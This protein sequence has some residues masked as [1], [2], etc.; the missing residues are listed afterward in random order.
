MELLRS[1]ESGS[2]V[3]ATIWVLAA[4]LGSGW[5]SSPAGAA[6]VHAHRGGPNAEG[7]AAYPEN[8]MPAFRHALA[9]GWTIEFDLMRS[10]D[11]TAVVMHDSTLDRTSNCDGMVNSKTWAQIR[12]CE[13]DVIGIDAAAE[14]L[15]QGDSRRAPIPQ[16]SDVLTL[17]KQ[18]GGRANIEVKDLTSGFP[19]QVYRQINSSGVK[20][21]KMIVQNF[22]AP[23]LE[24]VPELLPGA[25]ISLLILNRSEYY[26]NKAREVHANW[27][28]PNW[29]NDVV[30][31]GQ[32]VANAHAQ[33][34]K[35]VPWTLDEEPDLLAAGT[36]GVDAVISND[37]TRAQRLVGPRPAPAPKLSMRVRRL[38]SGLVRPG[39][40]RTFSVTVVNSGRVASGPVRLNA[41]FPG[42]LLRLDG[43]TKRS[44]SSL[45]AEDSRV[46]RLRFRVRTNA[47]AKRK[48]RIVFSARQSGPDSA[49]TLRRSANLRILPRRR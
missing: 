17:L 39:Q 16:L 36:A 24:P 14:N 2:I 19:E 45:P 27:I 42:R 10:S 32:Y 9:R 23:F 7:V 21:G 33:G 34:L 8:S 49:P 20:T 25:G 1:R 46:V 31:P 15:P 22:A 18:T 12:A 28:S 30:N 11:G 47:K 29:F 48:V 35:V 41:A 26:F 44:L 37:P 40:R 4:L 13:L 38:G 43:G 6:D 3:L 5:L